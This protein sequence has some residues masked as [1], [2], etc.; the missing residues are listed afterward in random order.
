MTGSIDPNKINITP[1]LT[2]TSGP[3]NISSAQASSPSE[4]IQSSQNS[5]RTVSRVVNRLFPFL[6]ANARN[7]LINRTLGLEEGRQNNIADA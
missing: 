6:S 3:S 1:P 4:V 7:Q 2:E 5:T